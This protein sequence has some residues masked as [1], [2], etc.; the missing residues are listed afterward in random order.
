MLWLSREAIMDYWLTSMVALAM[1]LLVSKGFDNRNW[2]MILGVVC[3]LGMLTKWTFA[4]FL[5]FPFI[6]FARKNVKNAAISAGAALIVA[7][8]WYLP[9]LT[10]LT[11]FLALNTNDGVGE[12]DPP[13]ISF[14][15]VVF[16]VRALEGYQVFL[17]LFIAFIAGAV[18]V[19]RRFDPR[20]APICFWI[21]SGWFGLMLFQN[22]DPR[23]SVPLLPAVALI[24]AKAFEKKQI[25]LG[26]PGPFSRFSAL[27]GFLWDSPSAGES[28]VDGGGPWAT[29]VR[30]EC[31][32]PKPTLI[33]GAAPPE[34]IGRLNRYSMRS[35]PGMAV[36]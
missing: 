17:P 16:Y 35:S 7:A 4:F 3:G 11:E 27:P 30:L 25:L 9:Q 29:V 36:R 20:W 5:A 6:W 34:R 31:L 15:A 28:R 32:C 26:R 33:S 19:A 18:L 12:G 8:Y 21:L 23:Y 13:R 14:Q 10:S 22:K 1:W 24:T 2:S